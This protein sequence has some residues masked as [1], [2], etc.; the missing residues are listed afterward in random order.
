MLRSRG[1]HGAQDRINRDLRQ[2][3][4]ES[5]LRFTQDAVK[6]AFDVHSNR[7]L[8]VWRLAMERQELSLFDSPVN[9]EQRDALRLAR[10]P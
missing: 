10:E 6:H 5:I 4:L 1:P 2:R 8:R 7:T 9:F 3:L